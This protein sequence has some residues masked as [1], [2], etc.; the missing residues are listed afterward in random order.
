MLYPDPSR[1]PPIAFCVAILILLAPITRAAAPVLDALNPAGAQR[2]T[3]TTVTAAGKFDKWPVQLWTDTPAIKFEP[4]NDS[5]K[6]KVTVS[7]D[8]PPGPHLVRAHS[9]EGASALRCFVVG[10]PPEIAEA[11]PND[12]LAAAQPTTRPATQPAQPP[13]PLTINAQLDKAADVDCYAVQLKAG[14]TLVASVE[15]RRL[16]SGIDPILHLLDQI[17]QELAFAHDGL[18][19]DP[20]LAYRASKD[21]T[22]I[23]RVTAFAYPPAAD[24]K[25]TSGKNAVYRLCLTTGPYVRAAIPAGVTRGQRTTVRLLGWNLPSNQIEVDATAVPP[26]DDHLLITLPGAQFPFHIDVSDAPE[27]IDAGS[28]NAL[29]TLLPPVNVSG[30]IAAPGEEDRFALSA[31][32]GQR[33]LIA[34]K[35]ASTASPLDGVLRIEDSSGKAINTED[36][37]QG[38]ADPRLD[39][40]APADGTFH[41]ILTDR[42]RKGGPDY[43]Y[44]LEIK[45]PTPEIAATIDPDTYTLTAGKSAALKLTTARRN[46]HAAPI[47][48]V[49][50][51]LPSGVTSTSAE[52]PAKGGDISL[53]LTAAPDA[54]PASAPIRVMLLATDPAD[55]QAIAATYDFKKD[56]EKPGT[57]DFFERSPD[58][59]LTVLPPPTTKPATTSTTTKPA[60]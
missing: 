55:P 2:G 38:T 8:A 12:E 28:A 30:V 58:L 17:G 42:F 9:P 43:H 16:G 24:I 49:V 32:K 36:D 7:P 26:R 35:A 33:L 59:W 56:K 46:G 18:G 52:V 48:A 53:T 39:W 27:L 34:V 15:G 10:Q 50:T 60:N 45:T 57:P 5:G 41:I 29:S 54:K 31:K 40:A 25:L 3:T 19:L 44:R 4:L 37:A 47:V 20:L 23:V 13:L 21:G 6:F 11:E 22:Y 14:Q 1:R 51:G